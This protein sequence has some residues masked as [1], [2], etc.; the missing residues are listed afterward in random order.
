MTKLYELTGEWATLQARVEDGEDVSAELATLS[1][2]LELKAERIAAVL[3]NLRSD[4]E[5]LRAEE[6]RLADRRRSIENNEERLREHIKTCMEMAGISRIKCPAFTLSLSAR[7]RVVIDDET[8]LSPECLRTKV[9]PDK[10]AIQ[11]AYKRDG[12][13]VAGASIET[14]NVLTIK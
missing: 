12:E 13:I 5:A 14:F 4:Q 10:S 7:E 9:E 1:D 2:S 6:K 8:K 3:R 11:A